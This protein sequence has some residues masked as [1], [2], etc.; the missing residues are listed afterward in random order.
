MSIQ[1]LKLGSNLYMAGKVHPRTGQEDPW[2]RIE[3]QHYPSLKYGARWGWMVN[4]T[5]QSFFFRERDPV[6]LL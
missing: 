3:M 2:G 4:A 5:S 1:K 6:P